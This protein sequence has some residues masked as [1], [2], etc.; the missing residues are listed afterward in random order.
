MADKSFNLAWATIGE[1]VTRLQA[2]AGTY[3][4]KLTAPEFVKEVAEVS[5]AILAL[6]GKVG[7][8]SKDELLAV[9]K[10]FAIAAR[11]IL[12]ETPIQS[13]DSAHV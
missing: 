8:P 1:S 13:K 11:K 10:E 4:D 7:A 3:M 5:D 2:P 12:G 6:Q 9:F